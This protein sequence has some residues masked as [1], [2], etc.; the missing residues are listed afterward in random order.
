MRL[1]ELPAEL[2]DMIVARELSGEDYKME[3]GC[4][5]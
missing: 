5:N 2:K 3:E 4:Y 1:R